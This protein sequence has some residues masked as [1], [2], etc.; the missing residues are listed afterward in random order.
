MLLPWCRS[1]RNGPR[2]RPDTPAWN[3]DG[4]GRSAGLTIRKQSQTE[5]AVKATLN[6]NQHIAP[7]TGG[8]AMKGESVMGM[9]GG[10]GKNRES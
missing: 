1:L 7:A 2:R 4:K 5:A 9:M 8:S 6:P 3:H 10:L